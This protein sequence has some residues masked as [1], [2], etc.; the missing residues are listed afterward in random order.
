MI[1][2]TRPVPGSTI[3]WSSRTSLWQN[4]RSAWRAVGGAAARNASTGA[5]RSASTSPVTP[6]YSSPTCSSQA[7]GGSAV[8][9][10]HL[11][12][13]PP[14]RPRAAW[15]GRRPGRRRSAL[16]SRRS[17]STAATPGT[18]VVSSAPAVG[19]PPR[20]PAGGGSVECAA[21]DTRAARRRARRSCASPWGRGP[22][23]TRRT[24]SSPTA[25][26]TLSHPS[27]SASTR[28]ERPGAS[29]A[30]RSSGGCMHSSMHARAGQAGRAC[31]RVTGP[32]AP[33][34]RRTR[35]PPGAPSPRP[36]RTS[37]RACATSAAASSGVP[38]TQRR[39]MPSSRPDVGLGQGRRLG[40]LDRQLGAE[41]GAGAQR[42]HRDAAGEAP[43]G[44]PR[45]RSPR[46][47]RSR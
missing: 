47:R 36:R 7:S 26:T 8:G 44:A 11:G 41:R 1:P 13:P 32:S 22:S 43:D 12:P 33:A 40:L 9:T 20:P 4:T 17:A 27:P 25:Q 10:D 46:Q 16:V 23:T 38:I 31:S 21:G 28:P 3:T 6:A 15:T 34:R 2:V 30:S 39:R 14:G 29:V 5:R 19:V 42:H 35:R 45:R 18:R 37:P 24:R